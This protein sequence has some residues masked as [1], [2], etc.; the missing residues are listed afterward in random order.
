MFLLPAPNDPKLKKAVAWFSKAAEQGYA[1][2][3]YHLGKM[4][5]FGWGVKQSQKKANDWFRKAADQGYEKAQEA[6]EDFNQ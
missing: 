5:I 1:E 3:Q 6:L 2:A 4:Y